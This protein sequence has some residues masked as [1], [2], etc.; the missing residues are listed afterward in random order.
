ME[1]AVSNGYRLDY[2]APGLP[3][4]RPIA[5]P[6]HFSGATQMIHEAF[7]QNPACLYEQAFI[8]G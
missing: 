1:R 3:F 2:T 5:G 6:A 8:N 4:G 7:L